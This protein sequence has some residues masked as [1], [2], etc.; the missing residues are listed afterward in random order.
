MRIRSCSTLAFPLSGGPFIGPNATLLTSSSLPGQ[1]CDAPRAP[2]RLMHREFLHEKC[3]CGTLNGPQVLPHF[4]AHLLG[5]S[6]GG[7]AFGFS[8]RGEAREDRR[9]S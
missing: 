1:V 7:L 3:C 9:H 2:L 8:P 6:R 5:P 4:V